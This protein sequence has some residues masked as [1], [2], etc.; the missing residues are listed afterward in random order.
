MYRKACSSF[1]FTIKDLRQA[2]LSVL[3]LSP[4]TATASDI[5]QQYQ[6][7]ALK[8][9]KGGELS[10]NKFAKIS[11]AFE[12][13]VKSDGTLRE[14]IDYILWK[15]SFTDPHT[16]FQQHCC[17]ENEGSGN[18]FRKKISQRY[19][20]CPASQSMRASIKRDIS[21]TS[22]HQDDSICLV[23]CTRQRLVSV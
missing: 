13:L 7:L 19:D 9:C 2:A 11:A 5:K 23:R 12:I 15:A 20:V 14:N 6:T 8:Y 10:D 18:S 22:T 17:Y 21:C 4:S 16:L 1:Y 3:G